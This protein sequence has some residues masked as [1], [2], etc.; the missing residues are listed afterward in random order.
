[1]ILIALKLF[2]LFAVLTLATAPRTSLRGRIWQD[3]LV[4]PLARK[5]GR[6]TRGHVLLTLGLAAFFSLLVWLL[7]GDGL[8]VSSMALP[9]VTTWAMTFEISTLLDAMAAVAIMAATVRIRTMGTFVSNLLRAPF[10]RTRLRTA[11]TR[12]RS[13][14]RPTSANDDDPHVVLIAA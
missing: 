4:I 10:R 11:R 1:M 13:R 3:G 7:G 9:E 14:I 6:I 2:S 12:R 5:L 8:R